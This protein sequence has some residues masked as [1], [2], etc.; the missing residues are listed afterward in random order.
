MILA[1][2]YFLNGDFNN[3]LMKMDFLKK[4]EPLIKVVK[5]FCFNN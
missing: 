3:C 1:G 4:L 2:I 5:K